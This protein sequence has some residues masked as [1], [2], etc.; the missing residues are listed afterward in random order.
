MK[1]YLNEKQ[2]IYITLFILINTQGCHSGDKIWKKKKIFSLPKADF[3]GILQPFL[4]KEVD[5]V[6]IREGAFIRIKQ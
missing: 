6:I 2:L 4:P 5:W 1:I 3:G